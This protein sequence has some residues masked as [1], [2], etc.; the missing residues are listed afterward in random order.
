MAA[1]GRAGKANATRQASTAPAAARTGGRP[2]AGPPDSTRGRVPSKPI[3][4]KPSKSAW[5]C[6]FLFGFIWWNRGFSKGY[7]QKNKKNF[8]PLKLASRVVFKAA[9]TA[10]LRH[11]GPHPPRRARQ[12]CYSK[13][14]SQCFWFCQYFSSAIGRPAHGIGRPKL[15]GAAAPRFSLRPRTPLPRRNAARWSRIPLRVPSHATF[16]DPAADRRRGD[17]AAAQA[18]GIGCPA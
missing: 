3:Q 18:R 12:S 7:E 15:G 2:P 14:I 5:I 10:S 8:P 1:R 4:I 11:P 13:I 9:R 6:L 17:L 16:A